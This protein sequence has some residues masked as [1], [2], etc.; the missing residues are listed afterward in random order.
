M[1]IYNILVNRYYLLFIHVQCT[2]FLLLKIIFEIN[3]FVS[4][5]ESD[6]KKPDIVDATK[7]GIYKFICID[8]ASDQT[9]KVY[10]YRQC[11]RSD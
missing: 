8:N 5:S 9:V 10:L 1:Y 6:D 7:K 2:L 3:N 4:F 11:I